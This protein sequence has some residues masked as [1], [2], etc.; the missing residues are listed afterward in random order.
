MQPKE[1]KRNYQFHQLQKLEIEGNEISSGWRSLKDE[2]GI[3]GE[4]H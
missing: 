1:W 2:I 4:A 3:S